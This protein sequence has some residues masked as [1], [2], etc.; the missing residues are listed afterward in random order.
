MKVSTVLP[1]FVSLIVFSACSSDADEEFE[2]LL[3]DE[4][5]ENSENQNDPDALVGDFTAADY[6]LLSA[7]LSLDENL[8]DYTVELPNF[9]F[10]NQLQNE[11][12]TPNTNPVTDMGAT[13]GRVLFYDRRLSANNTISCASC[14]I[15]ENGFSDPDQFSL[16]FEGGLTGRNSMG[17]ANARFYENGRFFWD[18]RAASLEEQ[19]L[20]PIQDEVEMGLTLAE[21]E[22]KLQ[23]E[24]YYQVLFRLTFGD[25]TVTSNR[26]SLALAQFVRAMVSYQSKYDLGRAQVN[27]EEANFPNFTASENLGKNLFFSNRTRCSDCHHTNSF[28]GDAARNNGLDAA[29]IDLGVGGVTGN[30]NQVGEFKVNSLRNIALTAPYM[31]DGRFETLEEVIAHYN[32]GVQ[33]SPTL[34]NRL[35]INN[36]NVRRLNLTQVEIQGLVDFLETLT[37]ETFVNDEKF[38]DPFIN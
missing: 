25:E 37:D 17:L 15:Q 27:D 3:P 36:G 12:N 18:E 10:D 19:V 20:L 6:A 32:N 13:L 21:M 31:H 34:D 29:F 4:T 5:Q 23:A 33:N 8:E 1:L 7:S 38:A 30:N 16:G 11:D 14:H 35:R 26:V 22:E 9:F 2:V 24:D 28:V